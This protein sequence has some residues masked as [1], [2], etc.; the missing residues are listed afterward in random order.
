M[1]VKGSNGRLII[2]PICTITNFVK[3]EHSARIWAFRSVSTPVCQHYRYL[4]SDKKVA[5]A[6]EE[7]ARAR[8]DRGETLP[9]LKRTEDITYDQD[10]S[11]EI[12][13]AG[14]LFVISIKA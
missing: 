4:T 6:K 7:A 8:P 5:P 11:L 3:Y 2:N 10:S 9:L 12:T 13:R 1:A 14:I